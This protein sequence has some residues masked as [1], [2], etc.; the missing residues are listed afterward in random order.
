MI[1]L[2]IKKKEMMINSEKRKLLRD[3]YQSH[4]LFHKTFF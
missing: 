1:N 4:I 2:P 3:H